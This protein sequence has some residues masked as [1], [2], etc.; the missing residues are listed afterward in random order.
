MSR[1]ARRSVVITIHSQIGKQM[2]RSCVIFPDQTLSV[3]D[4]CAGE[5]RAMAMITA[6]SKAAPSLRDVRRS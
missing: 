3:L 4:P 5:G 1:L 6:S 2:I